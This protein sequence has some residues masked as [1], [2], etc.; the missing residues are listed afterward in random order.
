[1]NVDVTLFPPLRENR[2][3]KSA[4]TLAD[5]AT[6]QSLLDKLMIDREQVESIYVNGREA[7]FDQRLHAG[8]RITF[9]PFI[10]GG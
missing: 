1:M 9:L 5:S 6:V 10:G 3:S 8:D 2:F 7:S 4:V